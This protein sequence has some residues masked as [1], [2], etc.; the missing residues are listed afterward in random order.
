MSALVAGC[1]RRGMLPF[2]NFNRI[3]I[4]PPL[5][6]TQ[7]QVLAGIDILQASLTEARGDR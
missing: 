2:T 6:I 3:H 4:V 5:T 7:D 1:T